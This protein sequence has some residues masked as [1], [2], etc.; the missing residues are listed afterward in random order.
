MNTGPCLSSLYPSEEYWFQYAVYYELPG[1]ASRADYV[2]VEDTCMRFTQTGSTM[3]TVVHLFAWGKG[4]YV[5]VSQG[6]TLTVAASLNSYT[7]LALWFGDVFKIQD[8][9][10]ASFKTLGNSMIVFNSI[11]IL[12]L[13]F[14]RT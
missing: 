10:V 7:T 1:S 4:I 6:F 2:A 9:T 12:I 13:T 5:S 14:Y 3:K 8:G 11:I